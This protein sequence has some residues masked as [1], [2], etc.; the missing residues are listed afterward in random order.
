MDAIKPLVEGI[1]KT[2]YDDLSPVVIEE[3]K[4]SILDT[5]ACMFAGSAKEGCKEIVEQI[6]DWGG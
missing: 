2:E 5:L 4:K 1:I 6:R 3:T